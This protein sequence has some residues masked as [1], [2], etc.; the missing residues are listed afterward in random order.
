MGLARRAGRSAV[1][2]VQRAI[3][4]V[5]ADPVG[6]AQVAAGRVE[7]EGLDLLGR[8]APV[9]PELPGVG[10]RDRI[11]AAPTED[12]LAY[13]DSLPESERRAL[14][15]AEIDKGVAGGLSKRTFDGDRVVRIFATQIAAQRRA[16]EALALVVARLESRLSRT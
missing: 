12:D 8:D 1:G 11:F 10:D 9:R 3:E 16:I 13:F 2:T 4:R 15:R 6:E 14:L 5:G 7:E